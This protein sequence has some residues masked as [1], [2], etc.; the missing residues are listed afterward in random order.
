MEQLS[1]SFDE[2]LVLL[3]VDEIY[4]GADQSLLT[5]LKEDRRLERKP[6]GTHGRALGEYFSMWA[7]TVPE[8]GIIVVGQENDG[9]LTGCQ[10]LSQDELNHLEKACRIYCPDARS[11][12][13]RVRVIDVDGHENFVLLFRVQYR[14]DRVVKDVSG[15]AFSRVADDKCKLSPDEIRELQ[16]DKGQIDLEQEPVD[17]KFPDDFRMDLIRTFSDG[18]R[19]ARKLTQEHGDAEILEHRRLGRIKGGVFIPNVACALLFAKDPNSLFPGCSI[20][21]LRYEGETEETGERYNVIKDFWPEGCIPD[22]IVEIANIL[23]SQLREFRKLGDDGKFYT[24]PEYPR[25][26]WYEA[27]VNACVHRSYGLKNTNVFVK[28]FDDRLVVESPGAFPPFVTPDNIYNSQHP[29][30]PNLMKAMFYLDFVKCHNEGTRRMRDAMQGRRL[31]LPKFE[32]KEV[33]AGY[34]S[35]RVTLQ[36]NRKQRKVWIDSDVTKF[37]PEHLAKDLSQEETRILNRIVEHG[38]IN[39]NECHRLLPHIKTWHSV[40]KLL[41]RM[42]DKG[43]LVHKHRNDIE[44]DPDACFVLPER[45]KEN[46]RQT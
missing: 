11:D 46:G 36:N 35:V 38:S 10:R 19:S 7:N 22:L 42:T 34:I 12:S 15:D 4:Q 31:P 16:I 9:R 17:L 25:E 33:A 1:L 20:R 5:L 41:M 45:P 18:V 29:R 8:G 3:G 13:K 43:L 40:K 21:F 30:N 14:E 32:Q 6:A 24:D 37:V 28:M 23:E 39:V 27:I 26:A 2:K 44:R